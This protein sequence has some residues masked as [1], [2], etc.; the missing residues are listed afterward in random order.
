ME[1]INI[2]RFLFEEIDKQNDKILIKEKE[3]NHLKN[4]LRMKIGD[5]VIAT[6]NNEFDFVC[7]IVDIQKNHTILS[8]LESR[9]NLSN[10]KFD[11]SV[12]QALIKGDNMNLVV[13]KM[14][15]LG[16]SKLFPF[17]SKFI[18]SKD[19][20]NKINK[21]QEIANQ[22]AKQCKR[23]RYLKVENVYKFSGVIDILRNFDIVFFANVD[24]KTT[25]F[26][27][28]LNKLKYN[29]KD[30]IAIVIGSEGGFEDNEVALLKSLKNTISIS[31]GRRILKAE[32]ACIALTAI[33][34]YKIGELQ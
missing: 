7:K 21:F 32:T 5:G 3:H 12:F 8:V 11:V 29:E 34:M 25:N 1:E 9:Q 26:N 28:A 14:S 31:L 10:P 22:S 6:C 17:E 18:T 33:V 16:V 23:S 30:K 19:S 2:K 20:K 15:E 4:V 27:E 13:Q 24:E